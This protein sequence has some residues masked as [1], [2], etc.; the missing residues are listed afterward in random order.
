VLAAQDIQRFT[1][2][3]RDLGCR[4]PEKLSQESDGSIK[5]Y[6][7]DRT[8]KRNSLTKLCVKI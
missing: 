7:Q 8:W 4:S 2:V 3:E 6:I 5:K 1:S